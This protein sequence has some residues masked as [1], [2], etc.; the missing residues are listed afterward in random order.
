M[1]S[2]STRNLVAGQS[3]IR[4]VRGNT[5]NDQTSRRKLARDS[6]SLFDEKPQ[7]EINLRLEGVSRN[8]ILKDERNQQNVGDVKNWIMHKILS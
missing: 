2:T 5:T 8:A 4:D 3:G 1:T 7:S 6:V